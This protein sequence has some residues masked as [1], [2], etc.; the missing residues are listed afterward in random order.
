MVLDI[1]VIL[2]YFLPFYPTN[3]PHNQNFEK[4]RKVCGDI[5]ILYMYT[6]NENHMMYGS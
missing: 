2:N 3:N 6:I 5:I 4:M 1:F